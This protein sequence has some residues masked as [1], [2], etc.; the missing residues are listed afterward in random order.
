MASSSSSLDE[1]AAPGWEPLLASL[2]A[3]CGSELP[4]ADALARL[5]QP[6]LDAVLS[7]HAALGAST[8]ARLQR[9]S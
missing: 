7:R 9:G 8:L 1:A 6:Q 3:A 4:D 2:A 5:P